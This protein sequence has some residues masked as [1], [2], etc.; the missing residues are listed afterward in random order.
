V[1]S[2]WGVIYLGLIAFAVVLALPSQFENPCLRATGG[3]F[4]WVDWQAG[5][6]KSGF[7]CPVSSVRIPQSDRYVIS[8]H[9][10]ATWQAGHDLKS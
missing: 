1:F 8:F 5:C 3:G 6:F 7:V 9:A 2:I 4:L 10:G